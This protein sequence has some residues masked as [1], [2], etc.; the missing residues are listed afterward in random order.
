MNDGPGVVKG[1][2][3]GLDQGT[4]DQRVARGWLALVNIDKQ[5]YVRGC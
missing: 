5:V 1:G 2:R 4:E 3:E